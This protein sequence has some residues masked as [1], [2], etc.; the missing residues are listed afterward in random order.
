MRTPAILLARILGL[1]WLCAWVL[2]HLREAV[3]QPIPAMIAAALFLIAFLCR[4]RSA[5]KGY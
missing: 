5:G 4:K 1:F 3:A 2:L